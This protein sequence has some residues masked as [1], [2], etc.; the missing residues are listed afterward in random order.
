MLKS[1][2]H[3]DP[4]GPSPSFLTV[5]CSIQRPRWPSLHRKDDVWL[6]WIVLPQT[7][8]RLGNNQQSEAKTGNVWLPLLYPPLWQELSHDLEV[9]I[10]FKNRFS[11]SDSRRCQFNS[12]MKVVR[13]SSD[14]TGLHSVAEIKRVKVSRFEVWM[15][16]S[17]ECVQCLKP[18]ICCFF[19]SHS[20]NH[21]VAH[22]L[23]QVSN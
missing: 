23:T 9:S 13:F 22:D 10:F 21:Y 1:I 16:P 18:S 5:L 11:C 14:R 17:Q 6:V 19:S 4:R 7:V 12:L 20:D 2:M 8:I 15:K 3:P